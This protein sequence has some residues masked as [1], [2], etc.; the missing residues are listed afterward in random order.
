MFDLREHHITLLNISYTLGLV[1][2]QK[3]FFFHVFLL[4]ANAIHK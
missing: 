4:S 3:I 1:V 2:S